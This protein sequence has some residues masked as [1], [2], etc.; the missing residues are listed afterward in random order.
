MA[1]TAIIPIQ[2]RRGNLSEWQSANPILRAGEIGLV[3]DAGKFVI[4]NGS[5][6]FNQLDPIGAS[7]LER[8]LSEVKIYELIYNPLS[9][10]IQTE[11][12]ERL[13]ADTA[14]GELISSLTTTVNGLELG[15]TNEIV[16]REN[17]D[18]ALE[19]SINGINETLSSLQTQI[20]ELSYKVDIP[21][22]YSI[23][24]SLNKVNLEIVGAVADKYIVPTGGYVFMETETSDGGQAII[25]FNQG[26]SPE[27]QNCI[28][29]LAVFDTN[30]GGYNLSLNSSGGKFY[31]KG[32]PLI[33]YIDVVSSFGAGVGQMRII[34]YYKII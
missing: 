9:D 24:D 1:E 25:N 11:E 33:I 20:D 3:E 23:I 26:E 17:G 2:V 13:D 6:T 14:L 8:Y 10:A 29:P 4:G 31:A 7:S 16:D 15:L 27:P 22:D 12:E 19:L 28:I 34:V 30:S 18:V 32:Q 21:L 5:E